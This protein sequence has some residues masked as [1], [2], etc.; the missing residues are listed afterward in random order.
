MHQ[1]VAVQDRQPLAARQFE[2]PVSGGA[3][4]LVRPQALDSKARIALRDRLGSRDAVVGGRVVHQ[5][6]L[7]GSEVLAQRRTDGRF[8]EPSAI[9]V[10][11][12]DRNDR[13][14]HR[15]PRGGQRRPQLAAFQQSLSQGLS[16]GSR[17]D[18]ISRD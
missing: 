17:P 9:E 12:R 18:G 8:Q 7:D 15:T 3:R 11:H 6:D 1:V 13:S 10:G 16:S 14:L 5:N 2:R 4:P